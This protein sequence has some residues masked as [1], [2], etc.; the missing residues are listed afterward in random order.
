MRCLDWG[1][2]NKF[3][4][5]GGDRAHANLYTVDA[6]KQEPISRIPTQPDGRLVSMRAIKSDGHVKVFVACAEHNDILVY[7]LTQVGESGWDG[8]RGPHSS[9]GTP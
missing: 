3:F 6:A 4:F 7:H 5:V 9:A 8:G 1:H 2:K